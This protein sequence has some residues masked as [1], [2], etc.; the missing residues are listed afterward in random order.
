MNRVHRL[1]ANSIKWHNWFGWTGG[2]ALV[3]FAGSSLLHILMTW[4][5][6]QAASFFPPQTVFSAE[7]I[8]AVPK[9]L[10]QNSIDHALMVKLVPGQRGPLL[11]VTSNNETARRYFNLSTGVEI[12]DHDKAQAIWLARYYSGEQSTPIREIAFQTS[13]DASYPWI[14]RLLPVYR[15]TFETDDNL[16]AFIYTEF[17]A[18]GSLTNDW[19]TGIQSLFSLLHTWSW[20]DGLEGARVVIMLIFLISLLAMAGTGTAMVFVFKSRT[21]PAKRRWHRMISYIVWLPFLLFTSSGTYH[22]LQQSFM[23][24]PRGFELGTEMDLSSS[25]LSGDAQWAGGFG[26]T[27]VNGVAL[28]EGPEGKLLYRVGIPQGKHGQSVGREVRFKGQPV[29]KLALYFDAVTGNLAETSDREIALHLART[30]SGRVE[31]E[32]RGADLITHFGPDYDFRNKRL[33][34]WRIDYEGERLFVD[35]ASGVLVDRIGNAELVEAY[36]FSFL[37]KWN[38]ISQ[39]VGRLPRDLLLLAVILPAL[40][41]G[42]IG[43]IMLWQR[44]RR[45]RSS[46]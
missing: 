45:R 25:R 27:P 2:V 35:P 19:K 36:S 7:N 39:L 21:M 23:G 20:L 8:Q 34:V 26:D 4:T 37:H 44:F 41:A 38:M 42:A 1:R 22:L 31:S 40:L 5:G 46:N 11:Q 24:E 43:Y 32:V 6:P 14:N 3:L 17:G 18:L 15:V 30:L 12:R 29:E 9:V 16:T 10:A 13:F 28:M 33:P